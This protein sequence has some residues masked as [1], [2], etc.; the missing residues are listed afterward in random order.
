MRRIKYSAKCNQIKVEQSKFGKFN[1]ETDVIHYA[2]K[3]I[4][5]MNL[6]P[7]TPFDYLKAKQIS[8]A[9]TAQK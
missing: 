7:L 9:K 6:N 1:L 4:T 2:L 8:G 3:V 5:N